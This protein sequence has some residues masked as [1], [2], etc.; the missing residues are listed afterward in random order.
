MSA[1]ILGGQEQGNLIAL[2]HALLRLE[3]RHAN[4]PKLIISTIALLDVESVQPLSEQTVNSGDAA[5]FGTL[6]FLVGGPVGAAAGA[7]LSRLSRECEFVVKTKQGDTY[8]CKGW[9]RFFNEII[10]EREIALAS[11]DRARAL[12]KENLLKEEKLKAT[13]TNLNQQTAPASLFWKCFL[14]ILGFIILANLAQ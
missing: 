7:G 11:P 6:G 9:K 2:N 1:T 12:A 8:I 5:V 3:V 13:A 4:S 10:R 14:A